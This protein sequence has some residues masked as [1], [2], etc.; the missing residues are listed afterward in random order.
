MAGSD[1][2]LIMVFIFGVVVTLVY[3]TFVGYL[4]RGDL[5]ELAVIPLNELGDFLAGVFGPLMLFWLIIGYVQ[6]QRELQQNTRAL[7]LQA[8]ELKRSVEQHKELVKTTK[9]QLD[10]EVESKEMQEFRERRASQP[11]FDVTSARLL[12]KQGSKLTY[13]IK[14][15]NNGKSAHQVMLKTNPFI[16]QID[17]RGVCPHVSESEVVVIRWNN[18]ESG[19]APDKF[20]L[21]VNCQDYET[22]AVCQVFSLEKINANVYVRKG[23]SSLS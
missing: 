8:E 17:S 23:V 12:S 16:K 9:D 15:V 1:W 2:W 18:I 7:E 11:V 21:V 6:Q 5:H 20:D 4:R 19:E 14:L 10:L 3:V 13:E 22:R